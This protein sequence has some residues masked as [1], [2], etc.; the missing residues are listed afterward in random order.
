MKN[1][2]NKIKLF[3]VISLLSVVTYFVGFEKGKNLIL[4]TIVAQDGD[5]L[6]KQIQDYYDNR[7]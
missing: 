7:N 2:I 3:T 5:T 1:K 4:K 6:K